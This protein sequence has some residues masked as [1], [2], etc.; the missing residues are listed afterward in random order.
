MLRP[1]RYS[2]SINRGEYVPAIGTVFPDECLS[3]LPQCQQPVLLLLRRR[4]GSV[5]KRAEE[6]GT[7]SANERFNC[8]A[9][10]HE[11]W[12]FMAQ[13]LLTD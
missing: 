5:G 2:T 7:R 3:G 1:R 13:T 9:E 6:P 10:A 11:P 4:F 8:W 12:R